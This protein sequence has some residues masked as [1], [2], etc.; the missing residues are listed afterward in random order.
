MS[1]RLLMAMTV[2]LAWSASCRAQ[3]WIPLVKGNY[4]IYQGPSKW[5]EI[6]EG[7]GEKEVKEGTL[8]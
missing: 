6:N 5:L 1:L 3:E 4:W 8:T 2:A 7:K